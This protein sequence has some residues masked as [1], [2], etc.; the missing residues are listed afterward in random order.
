MADGRKEHK[1]QPDL[2]DTTNMT[3]ITSI[4]RSYP[5][6]QEEVNG[7]IKGPSEHERLI[8]LLF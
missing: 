3:A 7:P 5:A 6:S 2:L 1:A 4:H 8:A